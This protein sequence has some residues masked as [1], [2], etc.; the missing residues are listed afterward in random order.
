MKPWRL[1]VISVC[2]GVIAGIC[3]DLKPIG[4]GVISGLFYVAL[5]VLLGVEWE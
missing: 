1:S 4:S 2:F 3:F 5:S